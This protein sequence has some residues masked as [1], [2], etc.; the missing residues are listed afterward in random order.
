MRLLWWRGNKARSAESHQVNTKSS[1]ATGTAVAIAESAPPAVLDPIL[2]F[3]RD[4]LLA[5]GG[6][7]RQEGSQLVAGTLPDGSNHTFTSALA[8]ARERPET[9]LLLPG[10]AA[11]SDIL[12]ATAE[13]S[14]VLALKLAPVAGVE[15]IVRTA[16]LPPIASCGRCVTNKGSDAF[17][18][19][20]SCILK[21]G[22]LALRGL[23]SVRR[24]SA[25]SRKESWSVE[26]SY[27]F[28]A[29]DR[30]GRLQDRVRVALDLDSSEPV[31]LLSAETLHAAEGVTLR[32]DVAGSLSRILERAE[33]ILHP[34]VATAAAFLSLRSEP[35]YLSRR[36]EITSTFEALRREQSTGAHE[37]DRAKAIEMQRLDDTFAV[38]VD[39]VPLSAVFVASELVDVVL[40]RS[41]GRDVVL[42]CDAGR[43]V[44]LPPVCAVCE[45][46]TT[47]GRICREAHLTC[48]D[49]LAHDGAVVACAICAHSSSKRVP[50]QHGETPITPSSDGEALSIHALT[51]LPD[52]IWS[53]C[54]R[55]LVERRG[56]RVELVSESPRGPVLRGE[57]DGVKVC[58]HAIRPAHA[59]GVSAGEVRRVASHMVGEVGVTPVLLTP[60]DAS[61]EARA[62]ASR[63]GV[64]LWD[65]SILEEI[66]ET[67][68]GAYERSR[69]AGEEHRQR[70]LALLRS[71][72]RAGVS[73][74]ED[75]ERCLITS[76]G[77]VRL[78]GRGHVAQAVTEHAADRNAL[79]QALIAWDTL[80]ADFG[81]CVG[82]RPR[83]NGSLELV[84]E[85]DALQDLL[86]RARHVSQVSVASANQLG[87]SVAVGELGYSEWRKALM[88]ELTARCEAIRWRFLSLDLARVDDFVKAH[89]QQ[90]EA[91]AESAKL[92]AE[93]A[94]IR[95]T[96]TFASLERR[97]RL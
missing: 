56:V 44:V 49:C 55:W 76:P 81:A 41:G 84:A 48:S 73:A 52:H 13:K 93:H 34:A 36:D 71:I 85:L 16:V 87:R 29:H 96:Q 7:V 54:A 32:S 47:S 24:V 68:A 75:I 42:T 94:A 95:T 38:R 3:A 80:A 82:S 18:P 67:A 15:E 79:L 9:E 63:L 77:D 64:E 37:L 5:G 53:A 92:T 6:R 26:V 30:E 74:M 2:A 12:G 88:D 40:E 17:T 19:C 20:D 21:G 83:R 70:G 66:L 91:N 57:R 25:R 62:E 43:G 10:S 60:R 39:A 90:A 35:D 23:E 31:P 1:I 59:W 46:P 61:D 78:A 22:G 65:A 33:S 4:Y 89:D 69:L 72:Q 27:D 8:I 28:V 45:R 58:V 51:T 11:L 97:A 50:N 86:D 14:R